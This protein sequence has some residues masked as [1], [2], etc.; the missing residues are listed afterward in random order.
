MI[1]T[2]WMRIPRKL[3]LVRFCR[4]V[5]VSFYFCLSFQNLMEDPQFMI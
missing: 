1:L 2:V 3:L 5:D 4:R